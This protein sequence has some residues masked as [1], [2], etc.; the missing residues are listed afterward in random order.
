MKMEGI[1]FDFN[2]TLFKDT[3][4]HVD[5]WNEVSLRLANKPCTSEDLVTVY[6]GMCNVDILK[7]MKP[8]MDDA[9]YQKESREKEATYRK[10]A[11]LHPE[12]CK[13]VDGAIEL[14]QYLDDA[15]IPFT[16][17]TASIKENVDFYIETFQLQNYLDP[18]LIVYDDGSYPSKKEMYQEAAK[19]LGISTHML[20]F[21]DGMSGIKAAASLEGCKIVA[22]DVEAL[23]PFY[24]NFPEIIGTIDD[25][26]EAMPIV[27]SLFE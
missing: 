19:R 12:K 16:I 6:G 8:G 3:P 18:S 20:V 7:L 4:L 5:A 23:R 9:F 14:F 2:G 10:N 22:M 13:L 26:K 11:L 24:K 15:H 27:K 1:V 21:E 25:Y 17:A